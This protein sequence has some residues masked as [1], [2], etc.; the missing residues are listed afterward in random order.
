MTFAGVAQR[1]EQQPPR[2]AARSTVEDVG[3]TPTP[4]STILRAFVAGLQRH[5]P[6]NVL[7][8]ADG[9]SGAPFNPPAGGD[10]L[11]YAA[12]YVEARGY[13]RPSKGT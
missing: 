7:G 8:Y 13:H 11:S 2:S 9:K 6:S 5:L 12:G 3:S 10:L 1:L 4:R